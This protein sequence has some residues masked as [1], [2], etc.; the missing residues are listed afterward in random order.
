MKILIELET[1]E[2]FVFIKG[3]LARFL[4]E[5]SLPIDFSIKEMIE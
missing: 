3:G 5:S 2:P 4:R 1:D